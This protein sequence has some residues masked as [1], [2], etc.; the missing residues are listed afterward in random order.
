VGL[1]ARA[2][3]QKGIATASVS[4]TRDL[5]ES[6]GAPRALFVRWPLGHPLGEPNRPEQ[7]RTILFDL[8]RLLREVDEPGTIRDAGYRWRREEYAEPDWSR[9][10][11][12]MGRS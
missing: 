10:A 2:I 11:E 9:L 3:E 12:D 6:V 1:I 5:T 4:L 8:L 7:Q